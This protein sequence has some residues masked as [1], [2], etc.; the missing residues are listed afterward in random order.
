L[1]PLFFLSLD[2]WHVVCLQQPKINA[3]PL[4]CTY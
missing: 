4:L 3:P 1:L 2:Y